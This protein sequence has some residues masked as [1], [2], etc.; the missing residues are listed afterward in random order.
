MAASAAGAYHLLSETTR[1]SPLARSLSRIPWAY[2]A[3][4]L[5]WSIPTMLAIIT[6]AFFMM[7]AAPGNPYSVDRKLPPEIEA[8]MKASLGLDKPLW[9]QYLAYVGRVVQGRSRPLDEDT[10]KTVSE[11]IGEGL[12]VSLTIG[13][14]AMAL[15]HLRRHRARR[16]GGHPAELACGLF[17]DESRHD[18][19]FDPDLRD[20]TVAGRW[21]SASGWA[22]SRP[23]GS[24]SDG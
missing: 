9:Q 21:S 6:I 15:A 14:L 4:R 3:R 13:G 11:L 24:I 17:G 7:R 18:R 2:T 8:N 16:G 1:S 10:D 22:G 19:D 12:P 5:F 23:A 20:R